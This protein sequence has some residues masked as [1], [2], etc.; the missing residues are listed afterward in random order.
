MIAPYATDVSANG[1]ELDA[2][3]EKMNAMSQVVVVVTLVMVALVVEEIEMLVVMF[4]IVM[5]IMNVQSEFMLR[6][7]GKNI[8]GERAN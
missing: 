7:S 4:M 3:N 5:I 6:V 8:V 2:L 1:C